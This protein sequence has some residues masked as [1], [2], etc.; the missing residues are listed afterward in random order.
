[1]SFTQ[2]LI[3]SSTVKKEKLQAEIILGSQLLICWKCVNN[4]GK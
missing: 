3:V 4:Q 1:M 2:G